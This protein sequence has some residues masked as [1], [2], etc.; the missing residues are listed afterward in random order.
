M[1]GSLFA[2]F[3][4]NFST[5]LVVGHAYDRCTGCSAAVL[6]GYAADPFGFLVRACADPA[7]LEDLTGLTAMKAEET[8]FASH[9]EDF[10]M[11]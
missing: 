9:D 3:L 5:L 10:S 8:D 11:E 4:G 6:R 7:F 2:G 1:G